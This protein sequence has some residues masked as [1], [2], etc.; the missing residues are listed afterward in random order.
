MEM[1]EEK[2]VHILVPLFQKN[3][4][5]EMSDSRPFSGFFSNLGTQ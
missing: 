2:S 3:K 4:N 5:K 1:K